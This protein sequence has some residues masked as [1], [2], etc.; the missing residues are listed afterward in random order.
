[1]DYIYDADE[2]TVGQ[3]HCNDYDHDDKDKMIML[4]KMMK[5][6]MK[7]IMMMTVAVGKSEARYSAWLTPSAPL[8]IVDLDCH[9][10]LFLSC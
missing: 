6:V 4:M 5:M 7:M 3:S 2:V 10:Y 9:H 1:M 8:L